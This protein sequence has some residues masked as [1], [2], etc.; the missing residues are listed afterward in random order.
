MGCFAEADSPPIHIYGIVFFPIMFA[1]LAVVAFFCFRRF[2][3]AFLS[4]AF[5]LRVHRYLMCGTVFVQE[6]GQAISENTTTAR[7][8]QRYFRQQLQGILKEEEKEEEEK[9]R[10]FPDLRE[11]FNCII[12]K[13]RKNNCKK[14]KQNKTQQVL[15]VKLQQS[16]FIKICKMCRK[17]THLFI[18]VSTHFHDG[19]KMTPFPL[20]TC[21]IFAKLFH[22]HLPVVGLDYCLFVCCFLFFSQD[23]P[24]NFYPHSKEELCKISFVTE[25]QCGR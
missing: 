25:L 2:V 1:S 12:L 4:S 24:D 9:M 23:T 8:S 5:N 15:W 7:P 17:R 18:L 6:Q 22:W 13:L 3:K 14:T 11:L 20:R 19:F 21:A 10:I 16:T